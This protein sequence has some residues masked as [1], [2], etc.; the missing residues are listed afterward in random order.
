MG[1]LYRITFPNGKAYLGITAKT[2]A[3]RFVA[4]VYDSARGHDVAMQRAIRKYG[5]ESAKVETLVIADRWDYLCDLERRA[6]VAFGTKLPH[7]YN[8]T[9]GGDGTLGR[10]PTAAHRARVSAAHVGRVRTPEHSANIAAAK[11]GKKLSA[12]H[13]AAIGRG[14]LGRTLS[15]EGREKVAA[16][17]RGIPRSPETREKLRLA[18]LGK[19]KGPL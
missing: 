19:R 16:S 3:Q 18:N 17:K 14:Q 11:R 13:R 7:G 2:A 5:A 15:A 4:H 9:D 8:T 10:V 12:A 6:I 1:C